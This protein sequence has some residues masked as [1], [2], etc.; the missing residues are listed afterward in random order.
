MERWRK[1]AKAASGEINYFCL[2]DEGAAFRTLQSAGRI[3]CRT[4]YFPKLKFSGISICAL[5]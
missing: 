3:A 1:R 5:F 4:G 2:A